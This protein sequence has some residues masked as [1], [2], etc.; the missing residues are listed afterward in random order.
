M[1]KLGSIITAILLIVAGGWFYLANEFEKMVTEEIIPKIKKNDSVIT[2]DLDSLLIEKFKFKLTLNGVVILPNKPALRI[3]SDKMV[4]TY[5]P[6]EN[7]ISAT[8]NGDR[9][10]FGDSTTEI[11]IPSPE[12]TIKFN[13]SLLKK[14]YDNINIQ[15]ISK[16]PSIYFAKDNKFIMKANSSNISISSVLGADNMYDINFAANTKQMSINPESTYMLNLAEFLLPKNND[17]KLFEALKNAVSSH[18]YYKVL[19]ESGESNYNAQYSVRLGKK[20]IDFLAKI[21]EKNKI[22]DE[23]LEG[24]DPLHDQYSFVGQENIKNAS[25][26]D[27]NSISII[28]DSENIKVNL[29]LECNNNFSEEQKE[30][31]AKITQEALVEILNELIADQEGSIKLE[32]K[33]VITLAAELNK[34]HKVNFELSGDYNIKSSDFSQ[35]LKLNTNDFSA[36]ITGATKNS[37]YDGKITIATPKKLITYL[38]DFYSNIARTLLLKITKNEDIQSQSDIDQIVKNISENGFEAISALH[39]AD[40]LKEDDDLA[41]NLIL[42]PAK[43]N[44]ELNGDNMLNILTDERIVKFLKD[45]PDSR[46]IKPVE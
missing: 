43:F 12:Q 11:Y 46:D 39:E 45:M 22:L 37:V 6:I 21:I 2:A 17:T 15:I 40:E 41:M 4:A 25:I 1:K 20:Y 16:E 23:D 13:R 31:I 24:L 38:T 33:D 30:T 10:T 9:V 32:Q 26:N 44:F 28:N 34:V 36:E 42:D 27:S 35:S 5:N 3:V 18:H 29:N 8:F 14:S 19:N 7:M